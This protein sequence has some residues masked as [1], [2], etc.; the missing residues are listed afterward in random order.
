[1]SR[2]KRT[3]RKSGYNRVKWK[4]CQGKLKKVKFISLNREKVEWKL[5]SVVPEEN[6]LQNLVYGSCYVV[7][8]LVLRPV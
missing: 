8:Y 3:H 1:M 2:E 7:I 5:L 6:V 4:K